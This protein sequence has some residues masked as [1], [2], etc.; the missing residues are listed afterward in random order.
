MEHTKLRDNE[1]PLTQLVTGLA[2]K[3]RGLDP[4]ILAARAGARYFSMGKGEG[5]LSMP[6]WGRTIVITFPDLDALDTQTKKTLPIFTQALVLQYLSTTDGM[7]EAK[8]WI[9]FTELPDGKFY[10]QAFQGYTGN[11]L[12]SIFK[13]DYTA[14][15]RAATSIGGHREIF[16][17]DAFQHK[18]LPRISLLAA[19]W[20]GDEDFPP[21]YQILFDASI[22]HHLPTDGCAIIGSTLTKMLIKATR[23]EKP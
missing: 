2:E 1:Q 6:V 16:A 22:S 17:D 12:S 18:V 20:H 23:K 4:E 21:S 11:K 9:S 19:C 3:L 15:E 14:F 10:N 8:T 7:P 13:S 5:M